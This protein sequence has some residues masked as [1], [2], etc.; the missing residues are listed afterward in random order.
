MRTQHMAIDLHRPVVV[1]QLDV[2]E[3]F[4]IRRPDHAAVGFLDDVGGVRGRFPVAHADGE[5]FRTSNVRAPC[6]EHMVGRVTRAAEPEVFALLCKFIAVDDET[7]FAAV[8]GCSSD[9]LV[10][11]AFTVFLEVG[12]RPVG[13]GDAGIVLLDAAAHFRDKLLLQRFG[14][15]Q[16]GVGV[17]ILSFEIGADVRLEHRRFAQHLLP[18]VVLQPRIVVGHGDA[19]MREAVRAARR[20]GRRFGIHDCRTFK[21]RINFTVVPAKA[22]THTPCRGNIVR[23]V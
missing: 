23:D 11:A 13:R 10:L 18:V 9:L 16:Y 8:A 7:G 12:E 17:G 5:I 21:R 14:V 1:V 22:G 19:V 6:L 2:E 3:R 20:D 4:R 15:A